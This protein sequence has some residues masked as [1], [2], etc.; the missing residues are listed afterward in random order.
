M[1]DQAPDFSK[2]LECLEGRLPAF[3][4]A[5]LEQAKADLERVE[6]APGEVLLC[7]GE[8]ANALY[9][10]VAGML[11]ATTIQDD[12]GELTLSE[13]GPGEMAGEMAILAGGGLYSATVSAAEDAVLVR[14]PRETFE[15]IAK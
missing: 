2:L 13:F 10:V 3:R 15:R 11:R 12:G 1:T 6:L 14:V 8:K 7:K 5:L 9:V 4:R